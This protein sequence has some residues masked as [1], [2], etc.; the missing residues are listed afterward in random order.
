MEDYRT[1][2]QPKLGG[3]GSERI[4]TKEK[5]SLQVTNKME[6]ACYIS[7]FGIIQVVGMMQGRII[8]RALVKTGIDLLVK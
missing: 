6:I 7:S 8:W 1:L 4:V 2:I 3:L 5:I